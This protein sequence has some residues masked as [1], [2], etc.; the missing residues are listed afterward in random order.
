VTREAIV[1][2]VAQRVSTII[3][4]EHIVVLDDGRVVGQGTHAELL[5]SCATYQEIVLSQAAAE[6]EVA[7]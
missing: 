4:A 2:V 3:D 1:I 6:E 5:K 7:A